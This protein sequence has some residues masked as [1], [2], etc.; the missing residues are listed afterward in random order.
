MEPARRMAHSRKHDPQHPQTLPRIR[1]ALLAPLLAGAMML[2]CGKADPPRASQASIPDAEAFRK[3]PDLPSR[4]PVFEIKPDPSEEAVDTR[5]EGK[6]ECIEPLCDLHRM[7]YRKIAEMIMSRVKQQKKKMKL[8]HEE[9]NL[10]AGYLLKALAKRSPMPK[11]KA[12]LDHMPKTTIELLRG[13]NERGVKADEAERMA[14]YLV[15]FLSSM[16]IRRQGTFDECISHMIGREWHEVDYSGE[17]MTWQS[18]KK[19]YASEDVTDLKTAKHLYGFLKI[20]RT[21]NYFKKLFR[22]RGGFPP[23][24]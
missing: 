1:K 14:R 9:G 11:T 20:E 10:A 13:V 24:D 3:M 21:L 17:G 23:L 4:K 15:R 6:S 22:P 12:L 5:K 16:K 19:L 18:Q 8:T 7:G 2:G